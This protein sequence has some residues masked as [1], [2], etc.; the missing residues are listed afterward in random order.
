MDR[1][2]SFVK[3]FVKMN[4]FRNKKV[5]KRRRGRPPARPEEVT[6]GL[7]T[8]AAAEEFQ[9]NGYADTG[10]GQIARKAGVS[11]RTIYQLVGSKAELFAMVVADRTGRFIPKVDDRELD[12]MTPEEALIRIL[13]GYGNLTLSVET[14]ALT[15]LVI[16]EGVRFPEIAKAFYEKA[17][18]RMNALI[19]AWLARQAEHGIIALDDAHAAAGMLRGMML[20]EPQLGAFLGQSEVLTEAEI[21]GR[22]KAC[23]ELFLRGCFASR[24]MASDPAA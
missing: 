2:G 19:G 13:T 23:A 20:M 4:V 7:L 17:V 15:R 9:A 5:I 18:A 10:I 3:R 24:S 11:T 12:Q 21:G 1:Y 16:A 14:T 22:A 6:L 8:E